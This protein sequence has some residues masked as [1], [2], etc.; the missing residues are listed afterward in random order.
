[1]DED[2]NNVYLVLFDLLVIDKKIIV[3]IKEISVEMV[4]Y[5]DIYMLLMEKII[6]MY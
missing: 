1:M 5:C 2:M 3:N 6:F 4:S